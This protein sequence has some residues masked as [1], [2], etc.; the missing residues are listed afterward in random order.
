MT[1]R[2]LRMSNNIRFSVTV[3]IP[4]GVNPVTFKREVSKLVDD[5][6]GNTP[7]DE[8]CHFKSC[9]H[10]YNGYPCFIEGGVV[11]A[12]LR[13]E[14]VEWDVDGVLSVIPTLEP[15]PDSAR[16]QLI[17]ALSKSGLKVRWEKGKGVFIEPKFKQGDLVNFGPHC[18]G[19]VEGWRDGM[20]TISWYLDKELGKLRE[21]YH[22]IE[23]STN[24]LLLTDGEKELLFNCLSGLGYKY[25]DGQLEKKRSQ[26]EWGE[27]FY[28]V[29]FSHMGG[30][31]VRE[32]TE[33]ND[34]VCDLL[35]ENGNYFRTMDAAWD[36][37]R[38]VRV[39]LLNLRE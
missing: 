25:V 9:F 3:D 10:L 36:A 24:A 11:K 6:F 7:A 14:H 39:L 29:R 2:R 33:R 27:V 26:V 12:L 15:C 30:I 38:K 32:W 1:G 34:D 21:G 19:K 5:L 37:A 8:K 4:E 20:I 31:T 13:G 17:K 23:D 35:W 28:T 22:Q 18:W 16:D